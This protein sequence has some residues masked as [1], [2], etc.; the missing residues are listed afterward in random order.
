MELIALKIILTTILVVVFLMCL[1]IGIGL[2]FD[3]EKIFGLTFLSIGILSG[4]W[5]YKTIIAIITNLP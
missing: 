4:L 1:V 5:A 3:E 2:F